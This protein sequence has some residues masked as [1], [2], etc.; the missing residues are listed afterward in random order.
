MSEMVFRSRYG[1]ELTVSRDER[2]GEVTIAIT[3]YGHDV[4]DVVLDAIEA[5]NLGKS[6]LAASRGEEPFDAQ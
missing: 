2:D 5:E 6:I 3:A 4:A 1:S